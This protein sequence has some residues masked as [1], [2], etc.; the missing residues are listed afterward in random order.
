MFYA[1]H[2]LKVE[3]HDTAYNDLGVAVVSGSV[4]SSVG[5]CRCDHDS[6]QDL[7]NDAGQMYKSSY[8]VV[9]EKN[10]TTPKEGDKMQCLDKDGNVVGEGIIRQLKRSN[11]FNLMEFWS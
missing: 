3:N 2:I 6:T 11:V 9:A 5:R 10:L 8:H 7:V 4:W 1:P